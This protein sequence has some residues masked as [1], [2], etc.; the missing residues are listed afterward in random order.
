M[1]Y[2]LRWKRRRLLWRAFRSRR[3]LRALQDRTGTIAPGAILAA[4][5]LRNEI[6]RLPH[7][8]GHHR[9]L[10]VSHFLLVDNGST[11]GTT[12]F[13]LA[14]Q[15]VSLWQSGASYKK[16]RFGVDWL[17]WLQMRHAHG[18]WCLTVDADEMFIYP[19]WDSRDLHA[20]TEWL[21]S[22]G[23]EAY[24]AMMLDLYPKGPLGEQ[25]YRPGDDPTCILQWFDQ[26]NYTITRQLPLENLWIQGGARAR[27]FFADE[28]RKSPTLTK[29]PLVKWNRRFAYVNSAH[30]LL[31]PRLN[32]V[33][34]RTGGEMGSGVLL[35]T[36]F[37]PTAIDR[38]QDE[39]ERGEHFA[40]SEEYERY[41]DQ[42]LA[43]PDFWCD[44]STRL[45][46]WRQLEALG[47]M[48]R[49]GWV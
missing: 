27:M 15:D 36:K 38:A 9:K 7:F 46:G 5:T 19:H 44:A 11:D 40:R 24:P 14:Q 25:I 31:P 21:D 12:E 18:H 26:G 22:S 41:Y 1:A 6:V 17:T 32:R 34:D 39:R 47:L 37:L 20:L 45:T 2:R 13:L 49:G 48:S 42:L 3:Q 30:S 16:A 29:I 10:G 4:A 8:L 28:P 33:Y 43:R 35:H 23:A